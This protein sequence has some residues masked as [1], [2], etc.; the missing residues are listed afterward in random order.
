MRHVGIFWFVPSNIAGTSTLLAD[1][2]TLGKARQ[3]GTA[4]VH[5]VT[6]EIH[7]KELAALGKRELRRHGLPIAI[8]M[9]PFDEYPRGHVAYIPDT[10]RFV[11][12]ADPLVRPTPFMGLLHAM[13]GLADQALE[14]R[15]NRYR[16]RCGSILPPKDYM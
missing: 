6:H 16:A 5:P 9:A 2:S 14:L 10:D 15:F 13:F 11:I 1:I 12:D 3:T 4:I 8:A 7:W